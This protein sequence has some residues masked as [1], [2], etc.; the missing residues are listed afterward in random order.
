MP[1]V[2]GFQEN[3]ET[4]SLHV[5]SCFFTVGLKIVWARQSKAVNR[6]LQEACE[7]PQK[8]RVRL[9]SCL[10]ISTS[11][12]E[13]CSGGLTTC[14]ACELVKNAESQTLLQIS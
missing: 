6:G 9:S 3:R 14:V 1:A 2:L 13:E 10:C 5:I 11:L 8:V 4:Q 12:I 7:Q